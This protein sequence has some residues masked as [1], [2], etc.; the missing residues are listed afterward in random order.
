[1]K[2]KPAK[3]LFNETKEKYLNSGFNPNYET[4]I[5]VHGWGENIVLTP[6]RFVFQNE[7]LKQ[8]VTINLI[9][10][11]WHRSSHIGYVQ[12]MADMRVLGA[13][14]GILIKNLCNAFN[15]SEKSFHLLGHSVGAH[16]AG[17]A[18]KYLNGS[19]GQITGLDP[20]GPYFQ[21][22]P[23]KEARLWHTDAEFV[24]VIHTDGQ[25]FFPSLGF[26]MKESCGHVDIF[27][28]G[29]KFQPG[30]AVERITSIFAEGAIEA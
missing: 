11:D 4:K 13:M 14:L 26:G 19:V 8:N 18:G 15:I 22:V 30:C 20:G 24:D 17:Y 16:L 9:N 28:N 1:M 7:I 6:L 23:Q 3:L 10:M 27:P 25:P 12:S 2:T 29:G 21:G 5:L